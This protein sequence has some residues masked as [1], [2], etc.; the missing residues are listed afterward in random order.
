MINKVA[1]ALAGGLLLAFAAPSHAQIPGVEL[2]RGTIDSVDGDILAMTTRD[3]EQILV[4]LGEDLVVGFN[5]ELT[6]AD[7]APGVQL[8]VT[9]L[10]G[11]DGVNEPLEVHVMQDA[12]NLHGPWDLV[13]GAMMTNGIVT[14]AADANGGR[15]ITIHYILTEEEGDWTI[16]VPPDIPVLEVVNAGDRSLLVPG[17]IVFVVGVPLDDGGYVTNYIMAEKDGVPPAL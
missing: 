14:D 5:T 4:I 17:A 11:P 7:L 6:L 13:D 10:E 9:T 8:G 12:G 2:I 1:Y 3:N 15:Q 16:V